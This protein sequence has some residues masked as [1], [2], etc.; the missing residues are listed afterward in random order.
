MSKKNSIPE[1]LEAHLDKAI[2][3]LLVVL[4]V[5][6]LFR[7]VLT[8]PYTVSLDGQRYGPGNIDQRNRRYAAYLVE[9]MNTPA[10]PMRYDLK[11][12][13]EFELVFQNATPK[14]N[15][16]LVF[17]YP[18]QTAQAV[19]EQRQY[20]V[21]E[22]PRLTDVQLA[23][24]R[25]A[26][27]IPVEPL[28]PENPYS[29]AATELGDVD[30]V[31]VSGR[32]DLP[33]LVRN[34]QQSFMG[35]RLAASWRDPMLARPVFA[36]VELQRRQQ[37]PDGTWGEW[38]AVPRPQVDAFREMMDKTPRTVDQ[39]EY[40]GISLWIRQYD[41][42]R[43]QLNVLQPICYDF[44]SLEFQ[45]LPPK[46]FEEA[47]AILK[48]QKE[49]QQRQ[50]REERTRAA[51]QPALEGGL[52]GMLI[53]PPGPG[54]APMV[55][56]RGERAAGRRAEQ[57]ARP[58]A[59]AGETAGRMPAKKERTLED[60]IRDFQK[61]KLTEQVKLDSLKDSILVW[62]HDDTVLPDSRYQYRIRVGVFNPVA[63]RGWLAGSSA[64]IDNQTILWG[65]FVEIS[66]PVEIPKRL[67]IFPA[68][69]VAK[70]QLNAVKIEVAR[71]YLGRWR[72]EVFETSAGQRIG[73]VVE[74]RTAQQDRQ[75]L[76]PA[77]SLSTEEELVRKIDFTTPFMMVDALTSVDWGVPG[78]PN[79][80][81][82]PVLLYSQNEQQ[83]L[84]LPIGRGNWPAEMRRFYSDIKDNE[85]NA[86]ALNLTRTS[87]PAWTPQA[88][89]M[90]P[91]MPGVPGM[92]MM[93]EMLRVPEVP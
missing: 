80:R 81:E 51:P 69:F 54:G 74:K 58:A 21:P 9:Q 41:E 29:S 55:D 25:G 87:S 23:Y 13:E 59:P 39:M 89:G 57:P 50:T 83:I 24:V 10:E 4:S 92:P 82:I 77:V 6:V 46:Y 91:G 35:P 28:A 3:G 32:F 78:N 33:A 86:P 37:N 65:P 88:P 84:V 43:V 26:A 30:V 61:D 73:A 16:A 14:L 44:A 47:S 27:H 79:R 7:F 67:D 72:T 49:Q 62:A 93:P 48:R 64:D 56:Q 75:N 31:T 17:P 8:T 42:P 22:I 70:Q 68:E 1:L 40:G 90:M 12:G 18:S 71:Y 53:A 85:Q 20:P 63:G 76:P 34:F 66:R 60:V 5:F 52:P 15:I 38:V 45:W 11:L 36:R 2:L 19:Q